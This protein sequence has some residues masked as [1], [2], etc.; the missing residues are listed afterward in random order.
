M[1]HTLRNSYASNGSETGHSPRL[2]PRIFLAVVSLVLFPLLVVIAFYS[3]QQLLPNLGNFK[4]SP[5]NFPYTLPTT[6]R[7]LQLNNSLPHFLNLPLPRAPAIN[8]SDLLLVIT[9]AVVLFVFIQ[10]LRVVRLPARPHFSGMDKLLHDRQQIAD[11]LDETVRQ[12]DL[13]SDYRSTVLHCYKLVSQAMEVKSS[14]DGKTLTA[15][16]FKEAVTSKLKF[17]SPFLVRTTEL[18]EIARYSRIEIT[19]KD[20]T[21]AKECLASLSKELKENRNLSVERQEGANSN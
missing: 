21:E 11:I 10:A 9:I 17:D 1:S 12:L 19:E 14:I 15:S 3:S 5:G 18:F 16:E 20:A 7:Q 8:Y 6:Q 2:G 13:G 4:L